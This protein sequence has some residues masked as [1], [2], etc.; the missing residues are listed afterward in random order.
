VNESSI[1]E[2]LSISYEKYKKFS[3]FTLEN[4]Q[5]FGKLDILNLIHHLEDAFQIQTPE[6][7]DAIAGL[8]D[9]LSEK[10]RIRIIEMVNK[11]HNDV[12]THEIKKFIE[13]MPNFTSN[14]H[15]LIDAGIIEKEESL[16]RTSTN[17]NLILI[18]LE[19]IRHA[20]ILKK[21][22]PSNVMDDPKLLFDFS[23]MVDHQKSGVKS[24]TTLNIL[25]IGAHPGDIALGCAGMLL[26][27]VKSG[28]NVYMYTL[29]DGG[30]SGDTNQRTRELIE[31][32]K[33]IGAKAHWID[34]FEDT[35]LSVTSDLISHIES[36]VNI[37]GA[38]LV[39]TH[40]L[41]DTHP[42]HRAVASATLEASRFVPGII[43]YEI[44]L[45]RAFNPQIFYDISDVIDEKIKLIEIFKS[46]RDKV[47]F[48]AN[49]IKEL[50]A[51]RALQSRPNTLTPDSYVEA[52]EVLKVSV[53]KFFQLPRGPEETI[54][55]HALLHTQ[56]Y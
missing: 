49:A 1:A 13:D 32:S 9:I 16:V 3:S 35:H 18:S 11:S 20:I 19:V 4:G 40:S 24:G 38:G 7:W 42:D 41:N 39:L 25:A 15:V 30:A 10:D 29:T 55:E 31:S 17:M 6:H 48:H 52:F 5:I 22:N 14:L 34:H 51:Y 56:S 50:A 26:K 33:F 46:Q 43:S 28:L 27:A 8:F 36:C 23:N 37:S 53:E 44:P 54:T 45:T 12:E 21:G 2:K 47:Y